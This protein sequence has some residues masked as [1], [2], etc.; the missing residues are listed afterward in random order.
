MS[1]TWWKSCLCPPHAS[2]NRRG[3]NSYVIVP[4]FQLD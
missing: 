3:Q 4:Q 1:V 2:W